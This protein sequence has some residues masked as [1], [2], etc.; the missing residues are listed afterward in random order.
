MK[1]A[2]GQPLD[3]Y[4]TKRI[5]STSQTLALIAR[6]GSFPGCQ[7]VPQFCERHHVISWWDGGDTN[8]ANLTL[9]CSYH[10]R[11]FA[12]RGWQCVITTDGLPVWIPPRWIDP[13]QRPILNHRIMISNWDVQDPLTFDPPDLLEHTDEPDPPPARSA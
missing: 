13:Q 5:A 7:V 8:I 4:R 9:L 10:H 1:G 3:L 6:D 2:K 12:L 11:R